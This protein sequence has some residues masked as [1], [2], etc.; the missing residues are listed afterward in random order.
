MRQICQIVARLQYPNYPEWPQLLRYDKGDWY[1]THRDTFHNYIHP[2][3]FKLDNVKKEKN[4]KN[5]I[6]LNEWV[7]WFQNK[8]FEHNNN[9]KVDEIAP[10]SSSLLK[11]AMDK[12]S[13]LN[14]NLQSDQSETELALVEVMLESDSELLGY[15]ADWLK[16]NWNRRSS[17][18]L[19]A[20]LETRSDI[21]TRH[22]I[23]KFETY[24]QFPDELKYKLN[25]RKEDGSG[26]GGGG[27]KD[28]VLE[29]DILGEP[30][31]EPNRHCT[32]MFYL[33]TPKVVLLV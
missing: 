27:D 32:L 20:L 16:E 25:S 22:V 3:Q 30:W 14:Y 29:E 7:A 18:L 2:N 17:Y 5:D 13:N 1:K 21:S 23:E 10:S 6:N 8:I 26:G 33:N 12:I 11:Q 31:V 9:N 28:E 15:H 24:Y 19:T 4:K